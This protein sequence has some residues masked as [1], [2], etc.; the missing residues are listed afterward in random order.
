[1]TAESRDRSHNG[2]WV[3]RRTKEKSQE[4]EPARGTKKK[5]PKEEQRR[6]KPPA[7]IEGKLILAGGKILHLRS[8]RQLGREESSQNDGCNLTERKAGRSLEVVG[9]AEGGGEDTVV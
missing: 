2:N 3:E 9:D 4:G 6:K 1:M 8:E 5:E 7:S